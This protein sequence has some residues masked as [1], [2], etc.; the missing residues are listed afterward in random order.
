MKPI[1]LV[2]SLLGTV[3]GCSTVSGQRPDSAGPIG[4]DIRGESTS[5]E[6][7]GGGDRQ[8][9]GPGEAHRD[10][11]RGDRRSLPRRQSGDE[12]CHLL[13]VHCQRAHTNR[14]RRAPPPH[15]QPGGSEWHANLCGRHRRASREP[16]VA[17]T[18]DE[19]MG[20]R[21]GRHHRGGRY[22][23]HRPNPRHERRPPSPYAS[24]G[25]GS[26]PPSLTHAPSAIPRLQKTNLNQLLS[27]IA[28]LF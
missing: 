6:R 18:V 3:L 2:A 24:S 13:S 4:A 20:S 7:L 28:R 11:G 17:R 14:R 15:H 10:R 9:P 27:T 8:W 5:Q 16:R 23:S 22:G 25:A 12:R 26:A 21:A 1:V 19:P